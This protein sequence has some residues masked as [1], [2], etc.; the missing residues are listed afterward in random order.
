MDW[1]ARKA[2]KPGRPPVFSDA[3]IQFCVIVK[4]LFGLPLRQT[5]CM[6]SS[7]LAIAGLDWPVPDFSTL[8]S[9]DVKRLSPSSFRSVAPEPLS[10]LVDS[11]GIKFLGDGEWLA[12][13]HST[14][15]RHQYLK[16]HLAMDSATG[17]I[18][19]VEFTSSRK[20]KSP[21]LSQFL[22]QIPVGQ[23]IGRHR[24][25]RWRLRHAQVSLGNPGARRCRSH[26]DPQERGACGRRIS[27]CASSQRHPAGNPVPWPDDL[28][29][30]VRLTC[31]PTMPSQTS[32]SK[33]RARIGWRPITLRPL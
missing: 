33:S 28:E 16:V 10:L 11:T 32:Y 27:C 15:R 5:T 6:V 13:K 3:A 26:Y 25:R 1:V 20:G 18:R 17:N 24:Y 2:G 4:V 19:A 22:D 12:R 21:V 14:Y 31:H 9:A 29:T 23:K 30:M 8:S 7:I